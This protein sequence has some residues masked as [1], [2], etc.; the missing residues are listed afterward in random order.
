LKNPHGIS[1]RKFKVMNGG[2][3]AIYCAADRLAFGSE[4]SLYVCDNSDSNTQNHAHFGQ[5]FENN[6]GINAQT[7][8]NGT[9]HFRVEEIEIF[10]PVG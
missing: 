3:K 1:A 6:T 5:S 9:E 7:L 2:A 10:A 8:L 4:H